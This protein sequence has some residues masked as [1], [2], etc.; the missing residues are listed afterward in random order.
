MKGIVIIGAGAMHH[1]IAAATAAAGTEVVL[2]TTPEDMARA[3]V[4]Y[5]RGVELD[6]ID[7]DLLVYQP[8]IEDLIETPHV[9]VKPRNA[10]KPARK[11]FVCR[12]HLT[13]NKRF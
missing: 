1:D 5:Q 12:R 4:K 7:I 10:A 3:E 13:R 8:S 9:P 6:I 2:I 11:P